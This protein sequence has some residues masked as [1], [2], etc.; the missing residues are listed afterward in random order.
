MNDKQ[1]KPVIHVIDLLKVALV[2]FFHCHLVQ[3]VM[4]DFSQ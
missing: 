3:L 4:K 1:A 2:L